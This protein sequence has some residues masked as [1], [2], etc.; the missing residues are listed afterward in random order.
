[1]EMETITKRLPAMTIKQRLLIRFRKAKEM[2]GPKWKDKLAS[3]DA[4][5]DTRTGEGY[6]RSV[7]QALSD[8][9]RG[10]VDRIECV[11][12]AL[13]EIMGIVNVHI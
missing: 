12:L 13:E 1:M 7:A 6:M 2:A 10:D 9:R 8:P 4:F 11:T 3:H 5:F